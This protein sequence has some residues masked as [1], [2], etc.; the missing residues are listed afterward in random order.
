MLI[1]YLAQSL[2]ASGPGFKQ[3]ALW[4]VWTVDTEGAHLLTWWKCSEDQSF[5][6]GANQQVPGALGG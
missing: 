3:M 4:S 2:F 1:H 5:H 6:K